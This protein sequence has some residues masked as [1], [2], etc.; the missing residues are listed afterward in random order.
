MFSQ[1]ESLT[2]LT[3][4]QNWRT[5]GVDN[6]SYMFNGCRS[7][8]EVD[9]SGWDTA[10]V[11]D[12]SNMFNGCSGMM[13]IGGIGRLNTA[14][15]MNMSYMFY[16]CGGLTGLDISSWS[17]RALKDATEM[18]SLSGMSTANYD[19]LLANLAAAQLQQGVTFGASGLK[20]CLGRTARQLLIAPP[21][22]WIIIGDTENCTG[23][24]QP[25]PVVQAPPKASVTANGN[26]NGKGNARAN[27]KAKSVDATRSK[28]D[29]LA[30]ADREA[31]E[32]EAVVQAPPVA[33]IV[34]FGSRS[35]T[36]PATGAR[37]V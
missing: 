20:Y 19:K 14:N 6:L 30:Q 27:N 8:R 34:P 37:C 23:I 24:I 3:F 10:R 36:D 2:R 21:T 1:C 22:S 12:M 4:S 15:V 13:E 7:L 26:A 29:E 33:Q 32:R 5:V 31:E 17:L 35:I 11:I 18:L 28:E 16:G 25:Q 9:I